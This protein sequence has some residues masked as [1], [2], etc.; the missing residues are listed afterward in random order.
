MTDEEFRNLLPGD[1]V[2]HA[3]GGDNY[4]ITSPFGTRHTAVRTVD[5]TNPAEWALVSKVLLR[6]PDE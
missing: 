6:D 3:G 5:M 4:V 2:R 1:M